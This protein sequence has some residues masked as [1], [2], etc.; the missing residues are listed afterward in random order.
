MSFFLSG[1]IHTTNPSFTSKASI[2]GSLSDPGD[3]VT[4]GND[5]KTY[6]IPAG[7]PNQYL[8]PTNDLVNN[9]GGLLWKNLPEVNHVPRS[10]WSQSRLRAVPFL[11]RR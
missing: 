5:G 3:I 6:T 8:T 4:G 11:I 2:G 7:T 10:S 9:P 1:V